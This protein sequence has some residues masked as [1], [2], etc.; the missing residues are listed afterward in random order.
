[1]TLGRIF[2][3]LAVSASLLGCGNSA[4]IGDHVSTPAAPA[5]SAGPKKI[6]LVLKTL[7]NPFFIEMERGARRAEKE[8]GIELEVKTGSD[9]TAI[10]QQ[11]QIVDDLIQSHVDA[12][13][14]APGDSERLVPILKKAQAAGIVIINIDN[15]LD[16]SVVA[17]QHMTPLPFVS[18]DNQEGG[19]R[20]A[21]FLAAR[22]RK[23]TQAAIIEG[24][25]SAA[26]AQ[27]R[28]AGAGRAFAE[29]AN[30]RVVAS[31]SAEWKID[32]AHEVAR[33]VFEAHPQVRLVFCAN[34]MMALG[35][36]KYLQDSRRKDVMVSGYDALD[37]ARA[38]IKSGAMAVTIDQQAAEQGYQG[39]ALAVRA[40]EGASVPAM[41]TVDSR[42]VTAANGEQAA[43]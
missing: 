23:P 18:T 34:D 43:N 12:I 17:S 36:I 7:T 11:I 31:E 2:L 1:M 10:E 29:N 32:Q 15:Q 13:V 38:A 9:E 4:E 21:K 33:Q 41:L 19:Y 14:I 3:V 8:F 26:N 35:V 5:K 37:E 42:V 6:A 30:I 39:V 25:R 24:L 22:A 20:A 28:L 16:R 27:M 40:L